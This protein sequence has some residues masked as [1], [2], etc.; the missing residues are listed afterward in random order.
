MINV[1]NNKLMI[2]DEMLILSFEICY[3]LN[4]N[5]DN[6]NTLM[7]QFINALK[8]CV[9]ACLNDNNARNYFIIKCMVM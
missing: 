8:E 1:L 7:D 5:N 6:N 2:C 9:F 4:N 3:N